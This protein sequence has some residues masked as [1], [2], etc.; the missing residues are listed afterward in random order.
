MRSPVGIFQM[1]ADY[2]FK[3]LRDFKTKSIFDMTLVTACIRPSGAS[4]RNDLI[5]RKL[6]KNPS[7][8]I[9]AL[10]KD[11]MGYLVYQEDVIK[12][13]QQ[14]CGL[15]GSEAD[16]VRRAIARK[17][18]ERLEEAL[19]AI[20]DG[21]CAKSDK[22]RAEAEREA[23]EFLQ[24]LKDSA[25]YMFGYNHSVAYSL[26]GYMCAWLRCYYPGEF[27]TAY[28]N[29]A[30]NDADISGGTELAQIYGV[31]ISPPRFEHSDAMYIFDK[32]TGVIAKG[33]SS[34][35]G[36]G[37]AICHKF[38]ELGQKDYRYF[39]DALEDLYQSSIKEANIRPLIRIDYFSKFGNCVELERIVNLFDM[40]RPNKLG[41]TKTVD[42]AKAENT[43]L[44]DIILRHGTDKTSKG[45]DSRRL[46]ITD[47]TGFI[48]ECEEYILGLGLKDVDVKTKMLNQQEI[49]GYIDLTTNKQEDRRKVLILDTFPLND[50]STGKAWGYRIEVRSIGTGKIARLTVPANIFE[51]KPIH[52]SDILYTPPGSMKPN[53]KGF[54]YLY[55]YEFMV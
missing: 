4:Y 42:R 50:K 34:I 43:P 36:Y 17:Q 22:P 19:P 47:F 30:K 13:L 39:T 7:P 27:I 18:E 25:S 12:F 51:H 16:N 23:S 54:W 1:E 15:S 52:K 44:F 3:L 29:H 35:K 53:K 40:F 55:Q 9:D 33:I 31:T 45:E 37:E 2:A 20:M 8:I 48:H 11:N 49:L 21:Y 32:E 5:A 28:L 24:I 41:G 14:I 10:L 46:T 6:H 26:I 38:H